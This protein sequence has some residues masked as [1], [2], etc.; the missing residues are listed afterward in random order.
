LWLSRCL[1]PVLAF[2]WPEIK[3]YLFSLRCSN[4]LHLTILLLYVA[5][6]TAVIKLYA[7]ISS[8]LFFNGPFKKKIFLL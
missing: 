2:P 5:K 1:P 6:I 7:L 8:K 3:P 4:V